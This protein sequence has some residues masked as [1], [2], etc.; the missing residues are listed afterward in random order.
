[1]DNMSVDVTLTLASLLSLTRCQFD[2]ANHITSELACES[3]MMLAHLCSRKV[4]NSAWLSFD[5]HGNAKPVVALVLFL[6][7]SN[8]I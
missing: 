4:A 5:H 2:T 8:S 3:Y 6:W 7:W 1:M